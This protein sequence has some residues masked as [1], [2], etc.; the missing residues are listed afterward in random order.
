VREARTALQDEGVEADEKGAEAQCEELEVAVVADL[1]LDRDHAAHL[2]PERMAAGVA[3]GDE[4][5]LHDRS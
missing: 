4:T 1:P 3:L 2:R 5:S